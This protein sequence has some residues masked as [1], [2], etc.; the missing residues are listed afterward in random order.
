LLALLA[1]AAASLGLA[2]CGA[3]LDAVAQAATRTSDVSSMRFHMSMAIRAGTGAGTMEA[4]GRID[5]AAQR[6][7]FTLDA[8][9]PSAPGG[10]LRLDVVRDGS[11]MYLAGGGLERVLPG[12][13][14]WLRVDLARAASLA[15]LDASGL[16]N[17]QS[18]P[19]TTLAQLR[20]AGNVVEVGP[21][22]VDGVPTTRYS[23]LL[24]LRS[25]I[26]RL[27]AASRERMDAYVDLLERAGGRYVPADAW[28]DGDGYLRRMHMTISNYLGSGG[29]FELTTD[30]SDFGVPVAIAVPAA[31]DAADLTDRL[32]AAFGG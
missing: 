26:D 21:A 16:T 27:D 13:K 14:R 24:D 29:S 22:T 11:A 12:G 31:A 23:V 5:T 4:D 10:R 1:L 3:T 28:I 20:E 15:G 17:P 7:A 9:D 8:T 30:F 19:R 6:F 18:D 2:G 32:G 25:G